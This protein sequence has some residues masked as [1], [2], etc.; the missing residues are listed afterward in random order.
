MRAFYIKSFL[1][2]HLKGTDRHEIWEK[3]GCP[4]LEK[5]VFVEGFLRYGNT[6][7][8]FSTAQITHYMEAFV[9]LRQFL[10]HHV[11]QNDFITSAP[12]CLLVMC[13]I[14]SNTIEATIWLNCEVLKI[15]RNTRL[16]K[17]LKSSNMGWTR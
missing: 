1:N 8:K 4:G 2:S 16:E 6:L 11:A 5:L 10:L 9:C 13:C 14:S 3:A 15:L 7:P 17:M 12:V